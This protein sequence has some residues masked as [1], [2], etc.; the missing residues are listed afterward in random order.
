M[1]LHLSCSHSFGDSF[2]F[3]FLDKAGCRA[4]SVQVCELQ[5]KPSVVCLKVFLPSGEF[6]LVL[7]PL[8]SWKQV[9]SASAILGE[10]TPCST[11]RRFCLHA[12]RVNRCG[13]LFT[14]LL[15]SLSCWQLQMASHVNSSCVCSLPSSRGGDLPKKNKPDK[16]PEGARNN[17]EGA[18][19][20]T[21]AYTS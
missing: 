14:R 16:K 4:L 3:F 21:C 15:W 19:K 6:W 12:T 11:A 20:I 17:Q 13:G 1:C 9:Y 10:T 2:F 5:R 7:S 18:Q 8:P